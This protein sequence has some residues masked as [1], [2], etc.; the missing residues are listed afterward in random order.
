[1][2]RSKIR[3]CLV[4]VSLGM[5]LLAIIMVPHEPILNQFTAYKL[6]REGNPQRRIVL[7]NTTLGYAPEYWNREYLREALRAETQ[8]ERRFLADLIYERFNTDGIQQL[9]RL[10]TPGLPELARS[11]VTTVIS[12][13][14][15]IKK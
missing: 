10:L 9:Q 3:I 12:E 7:I 15:R 6:H 2:N 14:E 8:L 13:V 5:L 1:M 4:L 11:N